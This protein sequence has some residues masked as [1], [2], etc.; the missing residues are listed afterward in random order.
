MHQS[1][2]T[3]HLTAGAALREEYVQ[4]HG[5]LPP[6]H[7]WLTQLPD[8]PKLWHF[9]RD[10]IS[11]ATLL[12][13]Q[14][15]DPHNLVANFL[16]QHLSPETLASLHHSAEGSLACDAVCSTLIQ[17]LNKLI[18]SGK[19][20]FQAD[21]FEEV[22]LSPE[23]RAFINRLE[24][25]GP[26]ADEK[27]RGRHL[28]ILNRLL[29]EESF[30]QAIAR[31]W[32]TMAAVIWL[33][34]QRPR[35]AL[36][37]SGGG[38]RSATFGLGVLQG[39]ARLGVLGQFDYLSTVSGG[40]YIGSW[41]SSW[42]YHTRLQRGEAAD[43]F[44]CLAST[45]PGS[46]TE[47]EPQP[48]RHLRQFSNYLTPRLG[49]FS[50]DTWTLIGTYLRNLL[51][52]W[53]VF[54][55]LIVAALAIP[56][57]AVSLLRIEWSPAGLTGWL[58]AGAVLCGVAIAYGA[59]QRPALQQSLRRRSN[60]WARRRD[61]P[62]FLTWCFT[63]MMAGA[64]CFVIFWA[65]YAA[66]E[67]EMPAWWV[68]GLG[69]AVLHAGAW[70][71]SRLVLR[72]FH[73]AECLGVIV[74]GMAGGALLWVAAGEAFTNLRFAPDLEIYAVVA[75][76]VFLVVFLVTA[77]FF[78][79]LTSRFTL[80]TDREWWAR[81]GAW[82]LI[83]TIAWAGFSALAI[84]AP[85]LIVALPGWLSVAG[86]LPGLFALLVG[87][88]QETPATKQQAV[89]TTWSHRLLDWAL[90]LAAPLFVVFLAA[91]LSLGITA[92]LRWWVGGDDIS[93][94]DL[95]HATPL[96]VSA[97]VVAAGLA[98]GTILS[99]LINVNYFSLHSVYRNR[100]IRAYLGASNQ[101]RD[102][103]PFTGFDPRDNIRL[104]QLRGQR[105]MPVVN[106]ALNLV[107]GENLA[108]QQRKAE[109]FTATPLH[110]GSAN[111]GFRP[112]AEYGASRWLPHLAPEAQ[113]STEPIPPG[114][115]SVKPIP[116]G[117]SL[118]TAVTISGAAASPNMG[119][120]SSPVVALLLTLFNARLGAWLGNPGP[121]GDKTFNTSAP[122]SGVLYT[123]K[124]A[125]GLTDNRSPYVYLSDGGHFENLGLYEMVRRRC[126]FV[127]VSDAGCDPKCQ[128]EDLGNAIR[129][130]RIDL[131]VPIVMDRFNI[132][133]RDSDVPG[134]HCSIGLI[135]YDL[136][137]GPG[138]Q[139]GVLVYLK[140]SLSNDEPR[141]VFNYAKQSLLFPHEPTSDQWFSE[142]QFESY[143]T[144]GQHMVTEM[145]YEW[146]L[147]REREPSVNPLAA[148]IRQSYAYLEMSLPQ[149][150][151]DRLADLP[152]VEIVAAA[153]SRAAAE[154]AS[155]SDA[156]RSF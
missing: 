80:D 116:T 2:H 23:A 57:V 68:F 136:V 9:Q 85:L 89:E 119:Y 107:G 3:P 142:S 42:I 125:F 24:N 101:K 61:Q 10:H 141:D 153:A 21:R 117:L 103:N 35:A 100:L 127:V 46:P 146:S 67:C 126:R 90:R 53:L 87:F 11:R 33:S 60:F 37:I 58:L 66:Q 31:V 28:E 129:K 74:T 22:K 128:L 124:E 70:I 120:H 122:N 149:T 109:S 93:H 84:F 135:R 111:L 48:I 79:G 134:K 18:T 39:L 69:G 25:R 77:S 113:T 73:F 110:A 8:E 50:A 44:R 32:D 49:L 133:S 94:L 29:L 16:R 143:R 91:L 118:G 54:L 72:Q 152:P 55:P 14:L 155:E 63:P 17:D 20:L 104:H 13:E 137:D 130:I 82:F 81:M 98:F 1:T 140:P 64:A 97:S 88:N 139:P 145:A 34:H 106:M 147:V 26:G 71:F 6:Y 114:L 115:P 4:L 138:S 156:S 96:W 150:V 99:W 148:F 151:R 7:T 95:I 5:A 102:P 86:G 76:P 78:I 105:P 59:M 12:C 43:V 41:L 27:E 131:G 121:A 132:Q 40:G 38:I 144:L 75:L 154:L 83:G 19:S 47:P 62:G 92:G 56:R 45:Q 123:I 36:C 52:N 108:W 112:V 15:R 51:L 30:P 65:S